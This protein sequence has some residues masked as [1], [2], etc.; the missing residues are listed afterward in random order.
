[1]RLMEKGLNVA[2]LRREV[3]AD[4]IANV[5]V[6]NFKRSEVAFESMVRRSLDQRRAEEA[7]PPLR[8]L[9]EKHQSGRKA[10]DFLTVKPK[11]FTDYLSSMRNDG[12]NVDM[13]D[14]VNK[15]VRNQML[16]SLLVDRVGSDF[17]QMNYLIRMA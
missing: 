1:M 12:N 4:N 8:T 11:V 5:D 17:R 9:H 7:R 10:E 16:Y 6:P 2:M 14:E 3:L 13:E 15:M